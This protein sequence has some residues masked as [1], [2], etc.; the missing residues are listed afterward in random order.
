[1]DIILIVAM[2]RNRTIGRDNRLPWHIPEELR[3][4][5]QRTM[6]HPMIM[7]R[8][9]FESLG[10]PLPGRRHIVLTRRHDYLPAGGE[11]AQTLDEAIA[12][13]RG[14][15]NVFIIGGAQI[16]SQALPIA[17]T[18]LLTLIDR[19]VDGDVFFPAFS[20]Q[21]FSEE[22]RVAYPDASTP[23]TV[24]TYRRVSP[25]SAAGNKITT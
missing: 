12:L 9:T 21:E 19:D 6:G 18:I 24:I 2:A 17:T 8:K 13:C 14:S 4:F 25:D 22:N 20:A 11:A 10:K 23:F 3:L 1:M 7:G 15:G 5:K 16:F